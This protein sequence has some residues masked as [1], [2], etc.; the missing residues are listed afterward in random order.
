MN[1][2]FCICTEYIRVSI[3]IRLI[4]ELRMQHGN[5]QNNYIE[6]LS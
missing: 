1:I 2:F 6:P 3:R 5:L 4:L